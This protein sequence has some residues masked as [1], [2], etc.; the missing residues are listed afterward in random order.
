VVINTRVYKF[1]SAS[2]F[3]PKLREAKCWVDVDQR[4][5]VTFRV[6]DFGDQNQYGVY[7]NIRP[8]DAAPMKIV[9]S[10]ASYKQHFVLEKGCYYFYFSQPTISGVG[11]T[12]IVNPQK[13][14]LLS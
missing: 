10:L 11:M 1:D 8:Q 5:L 14:R 7:V 9:F 12:I 13:G 4:S 6:D 2:G 3:P